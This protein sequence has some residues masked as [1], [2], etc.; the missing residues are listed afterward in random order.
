[1]WFQ[2]LGQIK[3]LILLTFQFLSISFCLS[4]LLFLWFTILFHSFLSHFFLPLF[5]FYF[6]SKFYSASIPSF[7]SNIAFILC[8]FIPTFI[9]SLFLNFIVLSFFHPYLLNSIY[10]YLC[11]WV[12]QKLPQICTVKLRICIGKVA[13]VAVYICGNLWTTQY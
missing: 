7:L 1:M 13:W 6:Y 11:Y 3:P 4:F 9:S 5:P 8:D 10:Y 2:A 12:T